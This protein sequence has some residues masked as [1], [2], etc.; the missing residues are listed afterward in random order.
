LACTALVSAACGG[1]TSA[2]PVDQQLT[3]GIHAEATGD[4]AQAVIDFLDVVKADPG[5]KLAWFDLGVMAHQAGEDTSAIRD[6][7]SAISADP[8][9]FPAIYNLAILETA[10]DPT[11]AEQLYQNALVVNPGSADAHLN[12]G[13]LLISLGK[14]TDGDAQIAKAI[15]L[16]PS[17]AS[18][19]PASIMS[20]ISSASSTT[21]TGAP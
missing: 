4:N 14:A 5:N 13:F 8:T 16:D 21:T 12:I 10:K 9:Y 1:G 3:D 7:Q 20:A 19:V 11:G 18:R 17:L 15:T 6:Y 2:S